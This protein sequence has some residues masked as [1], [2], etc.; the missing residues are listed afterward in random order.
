MKLVKAILREEFKDLVKQKGLVSVLFLGII[1]LDA[2]GAFFPEYLN[3]Q[4]TLFLP[5]PL[6]LIIYIINT[7][8]IS[9]LFLLSLVFNILGI[10]N[11]NHPF[12]TYNAIGIVF[13]TL[14]FLLY[15]VILFNRIR[16]IS[17]RSVLKFSIL[18]VLL[19][20]VPCI[21]YSE[22]MSKMLIFN[23]TM[24]YVFSVTI[25]MFS[26]VLLYINRKTRINLILFSS[27]ITILCSS[28]FQGYNL[29]MKGLDVLEFLAIILFNLTHYL[30]CWYLIKSKNYK[31]L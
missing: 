6:I 3:R 14:A 11:F 19:V 15:F 4:I 26:A 31:T 9:I 30:M 18:I 7:D 28:Y 17:I 23:E 8:E 27:A 25:F 22:G 24:F 13:H 20:S 21:L 16:L 2:L 12:E 29:F 1:F 5:L 10:Y